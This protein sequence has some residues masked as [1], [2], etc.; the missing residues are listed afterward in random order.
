MFGIRGGMV[1]AVAAVGSL[2]GAP[3]ADASDDQSAAEIEAEDP[4]SVASSSDGG[5]EL[6][7]S[8]TAATALALGLAGVAATRRH[9]HEPRR[10]RINAS[11]GD[12]QPVT[13][14]R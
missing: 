8:L 12:H 5:L 10:E 13:P 14:E 6:G 3:A 7:A 2:L 4:A 1:V 11:I 9:D